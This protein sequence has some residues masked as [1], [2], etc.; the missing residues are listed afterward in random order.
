MKMKRKVIE[1]IKRE[2][3]ANSR[4]VPW[5]SMWDKAAETI[6]DMFEREHRRVSNRQIIYV[7]KDEK[8]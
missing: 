2:H 8:K 6:V 7:K 1:I 5:D 3:E 4:F